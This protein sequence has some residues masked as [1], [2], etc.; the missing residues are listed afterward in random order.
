M[1]KILFFC[2]TIHNAGGIERVSIDIA[3][4]L[5]EREYEIYF[6]NIVGDGEVFFKISKKIKIYS[7]NLVGS[8][9]KKNFFRIIFELRRFLNNNEIDTIIDVDSILTVFST[10]A[11]LGLKKKHI[12]W[13][14]FNFNVDL[15]S[16][17]RR[18]GRLLAKKYCDYVVTLTERDRMFWMKT[19]KKSDTKIITIN[20]PT[21]FSNFS[22][23]QPSL[24]MKRFLAIGRLTEQK[25]F[26]LLI[27]AWKLFCEN[28]DNKDWLLQI[29]GSGEN[30]EKLKK[31][32]AEHNIS[33]RIEF[34]SATKN[35]ER[36]YQQ[37][38]FYCM[39][40]RF[41]GLPMVLLEAQTYGLPII[42]FDCDCG[43]SDVI[44]NGINGVLVDFGNI[45]L[46]SKKMEWLVSLEN[47]EYMH[48]VNAA[49]NNSQKYLISVILEKWQKIL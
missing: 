3:N 42:S 23:H 33:H 11:L 12:C 22:A 24:Y 7:L 19:L 29:V 45:L 18:V 49:K 21:P 38:S 30:K 9:I 4:A 5:A 2:S 28:S 40:S 43:P 34:I 32:A 8:E 10:I 46:F 25:G 35:I 6:F 36:Y 27:E 41:E 16:R 15:G 14:H 20:N 44:N 17:Y 39:S 48:M 1:K 13:E 37:A 47:S 31:Q 26:D